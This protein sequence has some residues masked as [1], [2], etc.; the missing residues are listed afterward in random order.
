MRITSL[1]LLVFGLSTTL[2]S[3]TYV[4][5]LKSERVPSTGPITWEQ[6][7]PGNAG[8]ANLLRFHPTIPGKV[9]LC[10]DMWNIYQSDN[11]GTEWYTIKDYDGNGDFY[12]I[13]DLYYSPKDSNFGLAIESSRLW[14]TEDLGKTWTYMPNCPWYLPDSEGFDRQGWKKKVASLAI[15]PNDTDVWYVGGGSN[16]RGQEWLSCYKTVT[17]AQP[18][19]LSADFEG[20]LWKSADGGLSWNLKNSGIPVQAQVGR[21]IVNPNNSQQ[22]IASSNYGI[23]R[24]E[25]GGDTWSHISAG[26][27]DNDIIMDMDFYY[28]ES[29]G[30]FILYAIDQIQYHPNGQTTSCSG[31]IYKSTDAGTNWTKINGDLALDINQLTGGVPS[32]YYKFIATWFGISES[33]ARS[34]Y[35]NLPAQALQF[36]NMISADP[37]REGALY[38]G[39][40]D[41][42]IANSIMPGRLW[43]T[44]ND[45]QKWIN[46]ARLYT[47]T[48]AKDSAYWNARGNPYHANMSVGHQSPHMRFGTDYALRSMR[49]LDVGVDGS[50]MIISDHSTMLSTDHGASWTQ[51]DEDYTPNGNIVG[52]GNSNLPGLTLGMDKRHEFP[53]LASGEHHIWL[54][55]RD[56]F[57]GK[58]ALKYINS[59]QETVISMAFDPYDPQTV[60][61]TSSR[62]ANKQYIFR[63]KDGGY[64]WENYGVATP[65]TNAW[66]DDFY[67]NGL[68]IDPINNQY[69]YFGITKIVNASKAHDGGFFVSNDYGKTFQQSNN[70]LPNPVRISDMAFDPRDD[71]RK[72]LFAAA[73]K[74][75]FNQE[76]PITNGGLYHSSDRGQNWMRVSMPSSI[77]SVMKIKFDQSNRLYITTGFRGGGV[78]LWYSDDFGTSW[79]Q[80]FAYPGTKSIDVSPF[81]R[82]LL[83]TTVEYLSKNPGVFVSED[84][85]QTWEKSN[86]G[87]VTPHRMEDIKFDLQKPNHIWI[88]NLGSGFFFGKIE[89]PNSI[90]VVDI[91]E[92]VVDF[93]S[94]AAI[95][96]SAS[97]IDSSYNGQTISWKSENPSIVAVDS[98]G[99]LTPLSRGNTR[100]W[101]TTPDGRYSDFV[102]IV[103]H[104]QATSNEKD[105][106][107]S[108]IK[109]YPNPSNGIF[110]IKG[111]DTGGKVK[112]FNQAGQLVFKSTAKGKLNLS[113]LPSGLYHVELKSENKVLVDKILLRK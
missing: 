103:V 15:D 55:Q 58:Q 50:V 31:G 42:Q 12:H 73:Q 79:H 38:L 56:S 17:A 66:L 7:G 86:V 98:N 23:Y 4:E 69:M 43:T 32:N 101:A 87:L 29:N 92:N 16:V 90:Q 14:K 97:I 19:G 10:P 35:P 25:N 105:L 67:T 107:I 51:V 57:N 41:P 71:S 88:A 44:S 2:W 27:L 93:L 18:R 26:K 63:S 89:N 20:M 113:H 33:S 111:L 68:T 100:V 54:P 45:G 48:W 99:M 64:N 52:R 78:G 104:G 53:I 36:F 62:Q 85:G 5:R 24:S 61:G 59:S 77:Q 65:A 6:M 21:I 84:R 108:P 110:T 39:F 8:F 22:V 49:G 11:N 74:N 75:A 30:K 9:V 94:M 3:Q 28:N 40:A 34:T 76:S 82:N 70:G 37:S 91:T 95:Q 46:T 109:I 72:S 102:V 83:V 13:R 47:E 60:Y 96:L 80:S 106:D 112:V 1:F 81:D